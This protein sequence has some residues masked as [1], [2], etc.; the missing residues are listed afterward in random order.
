MLFRSGLQY[1]VITTG[2]GKLPTGTLGFHFDNPGGPPSPPINS[3]RRFGDSVIEAFLN[4]QDILLKTNPGDE[5]R[6]VCIDDLGVEFTDFELSDETKLALID[7]GR[8]ATTDYLK[9]PQ[10]PLPEIRRLLRRG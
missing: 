8:R 5:R 7:Q 10:L 6:T 9:K 1:K 4:I 3:L 2:N